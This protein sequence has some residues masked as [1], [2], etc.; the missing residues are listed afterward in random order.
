MLKRDEEKSNYH[1]RF[2]P[3]S[4]LDI[5]ATKTALLNLST[6]AFGFC[7]HLGAS[8]IITLVIYAMPHK[9]TQYG[10]LLY[11]LGNFITCF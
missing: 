1:L 11:G 6:A 9:H 3:Q 2:F 10:L 7:N 8:S 5:I 4:I